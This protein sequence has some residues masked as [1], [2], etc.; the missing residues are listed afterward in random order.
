MIFNCYEDSEE[1]EIAVPGIKLETM[2][3]VVLYCEH[4]N[5]HAI[6]EIEHP[7][8]SAKMLDLVDE[9]YDKYIDLHYDLI[10]DLIIAANTLDVPSLIQLGS[11][12]IAS[13]MK[14]NILDIYIYLGKKAAEIREIFN[15]ENDFTPE[16]EK[17]ILEEN[18]WLLKCAQ[19]S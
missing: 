18:E 16:E 14:G 4:I 11:A 5:T 10:F 8:T 19:Q 17:Q 2:Q 15:L 12:K 1:K 3:K 6:P 7:L 13:M 9:W